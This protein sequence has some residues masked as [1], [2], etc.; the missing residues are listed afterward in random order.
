MNKDHDAVNVINKII[1][2]MIRKVTPGLIAHQITG[3]QPMMPL[4]PTKTRLD[5][6]TAYLGGSKEGDWFTVMVVKPF[7]FAI[8]GELKGDD[9][10]TDWCK[11]T[12]GESYNNLTDQCFWFERDGRYYFRNESDRMIFVLRWTE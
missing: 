8:K 5:L 2:P 1:L 6:G 7:K 10:H 9:P 4:S 11:A 3:V 12:F